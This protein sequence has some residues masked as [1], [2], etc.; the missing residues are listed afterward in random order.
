MYTFNFRRPTI[1]SRRATEYLPPM[2]ILDATSHSLTDASGVVSPGT[3]V[4]RVFD[5]A[6]IP[7]TAAPQELASLHLS[8]SNLLGV[9]H[10]GSHLYW[11]LPGCLAGAFLTTVF[12][13]VVEDTEVFNADLT[14]FIHQL[15]FHYNP[16][17]SLPSIPEGSGSHQ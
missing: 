17:P 11:K 15:Y 1:P 2:L 4:Y 13:Q 7:L 8:P 9:H 3:N 5:T 10:D 12:I 6:T 16:L 14:S